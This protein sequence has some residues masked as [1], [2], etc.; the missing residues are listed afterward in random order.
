M[1]W[2]EFFGCQLVHVNVQQGLS[3]FVAPAGAGNSQSL[4]LHCPRSHSTPRRTFAGP[5]KLFCPWTFKVRA[6]VD[7]W[8]LALGDS[9][10]SPLFPKSRLCLLYQEPCEVGKVWLPRVF[11]L[12][13]KKHAG[14]GGLR[15]TWAAVSRGRDHGPHAG[16]VVVVGLPEEL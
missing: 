15:Q 14:R 3:V 2:R 6:G 1:V 13:E 16:P 10:V 9:E 8:C 11:L 4:R 7:T 12:E 5:E